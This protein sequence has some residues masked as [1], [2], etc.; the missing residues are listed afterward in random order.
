MNE[1]LNE[2]SLSNL[3]QV[4]THSISILSIHMKLFLQR[5]LPS[6]RQCFTLCS[7][8]LLTIPLLLIEQY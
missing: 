1:G 2:D 6:L 3:L 5:V 7:S 4:P 8:I